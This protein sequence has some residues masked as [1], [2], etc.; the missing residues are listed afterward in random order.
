M[1]LTRA[2]RSPADLNL[3]VGGDGV[4]LASGYSFIFAGR[5]Q[6]VNQIRRGD[7]TVWEEPF[8]V[9]PGVGEMHQDWFYVRLE[10][11]QTSAGARFRWSVNGREVA[12]YLDPNP[13]ADGG[14]LG[15]W[16]QNGAL[17]HRACVCGIR[18]CARRKSRRR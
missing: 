13:L 18:D 6:R 10:R 14:H 17:F 9:P 2:E 1:D 15:F 12:D 11:R 16:T 5:G 8:T 3:S 4:D 7:A